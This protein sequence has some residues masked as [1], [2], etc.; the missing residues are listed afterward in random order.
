M[1]FMKPTRAMA[2]M[3]TAALLVTGCSSAAGGPPG[4]SED[5]EDS[6]FEIY[7][8]EV[9]FE[10]ELADMLPADVKDKGVLV[11]S[12]DAAGP[13]RTFVDAD[14]KIAG[15][16]PDLLEAIGATLGVD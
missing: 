5:G 12:T 1:T 10:S 6:V 11:F 15:V 9:P 14:G 3:A 13:P 2:L 7:G 4:A 8:Q 16:I